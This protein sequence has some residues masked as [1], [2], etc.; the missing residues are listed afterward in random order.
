MI[1]KK[2]N[3]KQ[4]GLCHFEKIYVIIYI[5]FSMISFFL[6]DGIGD[7]KDTKK[8]KEARKLIHYFMV[9]VFLKSCSNSALAPARSQMHLRQ[10]AIF[11]FLMRSKSLLLVASF[12]RPSTHF[13]RRRPS[14]TATGHFINLVSA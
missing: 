3:D 11:F 14:V 13:Q 5:F 8:R 9:L 7:V 2:K 1:T 10:F 4:G 6:L 12:K